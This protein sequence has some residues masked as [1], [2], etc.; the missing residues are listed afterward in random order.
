M[1]TFV[2]NRKYSD[3]SISEQFECNTFALTTYLFN[4]LHSPVK[5]FRVYVKDK[6]TE[7]EIKLDYE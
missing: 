1:T 3:G 5:P 6:N 7:E 2:V 4:C